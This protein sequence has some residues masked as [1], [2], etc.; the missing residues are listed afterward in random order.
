MR[1]SVI[2]HSNGRISDEELQHVIRAINRQISED[3]EPNWGMG[4]TLVLDGRSNEAPDRLSTVDMRGDAILYL[5]DQTDVPGALGYHDANARGIPYGFVFVS[6]TEELG[7]E[8]SATLS[9]EAL[10]LIGDPYVNLLAM[11]PHPEQPDFAVFHWFEMCDAVQAETYEID[12]VVVSN[13]VLPTYF[14]GIDEPGGR[15]DFLGR[16]YDGA[17]L[18]SFGINPGGYIGF[19]NPKTGRH[20]TRTLEADQ[21]AQARAA[22]KSEAHEARRA[23]RYQRY[24]DP[25]PPAGPGAGN[26]PAPRTTPRPATRGPGQTSGSRG[27]ATTTTTNT[28]A[29][30]DWPGVRRPTGV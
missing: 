15:N 30:R 29:A 12:G 1:I 14:T 10:E 16:H 23:I 19:Y 18:K 9:H 20:E 2:N 6:L 21:A 4:A 17:P 3:F 26:S 7:E 5:W 25:R 8:W 13:F 11:G 24:T 22:V 28:P 27:R